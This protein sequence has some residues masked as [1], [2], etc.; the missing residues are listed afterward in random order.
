M[1]FNQL[2]NPDFS[3]NY[4]E[5]EQIKIIE[6]DISKYSLALSS[7]D[8]LWLKENHITQIWNCA[9]HI[10]Y[11]K[12][13]YQK[14]HEVNVEGT[15]NLV[16]LTLGQSECIYY[17]IS[18]AYVGGK[19]Y[20]KGKLL[21]EELCFSETGYFNSYDITK[22]HAE[23]EVV[24]LFNSQN[25]QSSY[26][27]FRPTIIIGDS[28]TGFTS[29]TTGF[30]EYLQ[31]LN[32]LKEDLRGKKVRAI[33]NPISLLYL[34]PVDRCAEAILSLAPLASFKEAPIYTIADTYPMTLGEM[35][36]L[37]SVMF[38][39]NFLSIS[40]QSEDE[41]D[42]ERR[43][44]LFTKRNQI[45]SQ[46]SFRF[47]NEKTC[48]LIGESICSSWDKNYDYFRLLNHRLYKFIQF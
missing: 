24:S 2:A 6:C 32:R 3:L 4:K 31:A 23:Q 13:S 7:E 25:R 5:F 30:Y 47:S 22:A 17:H 15:V 41:G 12:D 21:K 27:I 35:A 10:K 1:Q 40:S 43:L 16:R 19:D 33:F 18:T 20:C 44:R 45:F 9:A 28:V 34:I 26:A 11:G 8:E 29:S 42:H 14:C 36:N 38:N 48:G 46:H 37:L 39:C